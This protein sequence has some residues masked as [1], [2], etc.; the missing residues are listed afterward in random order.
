MLKDSG[1]RATFSTGAVRDAQENKGRFDLIPY[2]ATERV[3]QHFEAGAKKYADRNWEKG[4]PTNRYFDSAMRHLHKAQAGHTDEDHLAAAAWNVLCLMQTRHW[5]A[6][7]ILPAELETMPTYPEELTIELVYDETPQAVE[8][9]PRYFDL[10]DWHGDFKVARVDSR[11]GYLLWMNCDQ[12]KDDR[13]ECFKGAEMLDGFMK[14]S[15]DPYPEITEE[16]AF[17]ILYGSFPKYFVDKHAPTARHTRVD[18]P[19]EL[20]TRFFS[21]GTS[22]QSG[23]YGRDFLPG[24]YLRDLVNESSGERYYVSKPRGYGI[25]V[26][27]PDGKAEYR[28]PCG[29]SPSVFTPERLRTSDFVEISEREANR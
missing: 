22:A 21:D 18:S 28:T 6:E 11:E 23:F 29:V 10:A 12:S 15:A 7:G 13:S 4:I 1:T 25:W 14:S 9:F 27:R 3:A 20:V 26:V 17:A 2:H 19:N 16:R 5:I 24:G 8:T